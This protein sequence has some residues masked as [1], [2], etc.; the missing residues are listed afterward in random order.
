MTNVFRCRCPSPTHDERYR[1][2]VV[3]I[4]QGHGDQPS[5][6]VFYLLV[7]LC[8]LQSNSFFSLSFATSSS[9]SRVC[10]IHENLTFFLSLFKIIKFLSS[11]F[12]IFPLPSLLFQLDP[13]RCDVSGTLQWGLRR[14]QRREWWPLQTDRD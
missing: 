12:R 5:N 3:N 8:R 1:L 10:G 7:P 14:A 2:F 4:P 9:L 11:R 13:S 6:N